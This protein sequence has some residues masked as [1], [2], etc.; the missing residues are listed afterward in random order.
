MWSLEGA[1]GLLTS[2]TAQSQIP[3]SES[4]TVPLSDLIEELPVPVLGRPRRPRLLGD[5]GQRAPGSR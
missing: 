4:S 5:G 3:H 2:G 1:L